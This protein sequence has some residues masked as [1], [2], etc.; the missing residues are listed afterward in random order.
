MEKNSTVVRVSFYPL[1]EDEQL[2]ETGRR[3]PKIAGKMAVNVR[4]FVQKNTCL[5]CY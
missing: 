2:A 1:R 5:R 3:M 4:I